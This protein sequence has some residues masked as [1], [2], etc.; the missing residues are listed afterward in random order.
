MDIYNAQKALVCTKSRGVAA[1]ITQSERIFPQ[2]A[3][4][5]KLK[6]AVREI[7]AYFLT[8]LHCAGSG[9]SGGSLSAAEIVA[10]AYLAVMQHRPAEPDWPDRD[11]FYFSAG[12][13]APL[14]YSVLGYCGYFPIEEMVTLRKLHSPYQ[15]H[16]DASKAA[17][18][19]LSC[20][21]LGQG[22]SAAVG[23]ALSARTAG[24]SYRVFCLMGDGEQQ[25]GQIW[26]AVMAAAHHK[27]VNLIGIVDRN[28]LQID[29]PV[30]EVM[31]VDSLE[32]KYRAFGWNV[33]TCEGN[34]VQSLLTAYTWALE[35]EDKP[36]VIIADTVK[37]NSIS[38][39]ENR[40]GWHGKAPDYEQ[41]VQALSELGVQNFPVKKLIAKA[42]AYQETIDQEIE[43]AMPKFTRNYWWNSGTTMQVEMKPTRK[44]FGEALRECKDERICALGSDISSSICIDEFYKSRPEREHRWFSMGIAEQS[45]T[46]VAAGFA[47]NGHVPFIGTYGVFAAGRALDQIRTTLCYGNLNVKIAGAHAGV[48]V[49][50][51]G[52]TH[53]ALEEIFQIS[54]LPNMTMYSPIDA[55][56]T[57]KATRASIEVNGP[58]Y[59]RFAR[60]ATPVVTN[61]DDPFESGK[62]RIF[63]FSGQ[64][65]PQFR[66]AFAC[67][68]AENFNY[69]GEDAVIISTGP[70]AAE[71]MRAAWIVK[72]EYEKDILVLNISTLKPL[73]SK[74]IIAAAANTG[75]ILT[76]EEHQKGGLGNLVSSTLLSSREVDNTGIV[77]DMLGIEDRFGTSGQP[78]ELLKYFRLT[79]EYIA[80]KIMK[81]FDDKA[82]R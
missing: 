43:A 44:G 54:G 22:L 29:G 76:V 24:R 82:G 57:A 33:I 25:E 15:G 63:R 10:V 64:E 81:L 32:E 53:Q 49:G 34:S 75:V 56:E 73:D 42:Q 45:A 27:L 70:I 58:C 28:K 2:I 77:F 21:S 9:H 18:V 51:D 41:L 6:T 4:V 35:S 3:D 38:F 52:A 30:K 1:L 7:K 47:K 71:A 67:S 59:I 65:Q 48:S 78:W 40:A 55:E 61:R 11:R 68:T 26:E 37:G 62:A 17:G 69:S 12:H 36:S 13:K 14:W 60:E 20:G 19:E 66:D 16:P 72:E 79:A 8:A 50:P 80:V 23:D 74:A 39:M 46:S 31:N 5:E